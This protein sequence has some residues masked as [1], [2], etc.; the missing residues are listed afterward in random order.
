MTSGYL[1]ISVMSP[2]SVTSG[3]VLTDEN[4]FHWEFIMRMA[5]ARKGVLERVKKEPDTL[6][7]SSTWKADDLKVLA[8]I[9]KLIS[10][11]YQTM[12]RT[13]QSAYDVWDTLRS[14]SYSRTF[15]IRYS[16]ETAEQG[17]A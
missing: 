16:Y 3:D 8:I 15:T 2:T 13:A 12:V 5:L 11:T 14:F 17:T 4:Y 7:Q 1:S 10:P 9:V 6:Q